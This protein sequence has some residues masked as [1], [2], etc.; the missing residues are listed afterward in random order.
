[1]NVIVTVSINSFNYTKLL[2]KIPEPIGRRHGF[3]TSIFL[4]CDSYSKIS[5]RIPEQTINFVDT[6]RYNFC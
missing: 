2:Q 4:E 3:K 6:P 5:D 1:M